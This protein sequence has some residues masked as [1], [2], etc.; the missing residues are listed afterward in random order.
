M[1]PPEEYSLEGGSLKIFI[2]NA[3]EEELEIEIEI[4][5]DRDR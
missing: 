5:T 2:L 1:V 3:R 4:E